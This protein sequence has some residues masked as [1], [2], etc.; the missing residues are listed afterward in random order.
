MGEWFQQLSHVLV[1][2]FSVEAHMSF[3]LGMIFG[4]LLGG[5]GAFIYLS[6]TKQI[7]LKEKE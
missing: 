3:L 1:T 6:I 7:A 4:I 2:Y 5:A